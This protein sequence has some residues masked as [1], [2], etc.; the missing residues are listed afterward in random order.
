MHGPVVTVSVETHVAG[1]TPPANAK[2]RAASYTDCFEGAGWGH[3]VDA[4]GGVEWTE[5][6][7]PT[8]QVWPIESPWTIAKRVP[9][10]AAFSRAFLAQMTRPRSKIASS[11]TRKIG[12]TSAS[13]TR[14][15]PF[16]RP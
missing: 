8:G 7:G 16:G 4:D 14:A 1:R 2:A 13:S 10:R 9:S 11:I 6:L 15:W 12:R 5:P 3:A